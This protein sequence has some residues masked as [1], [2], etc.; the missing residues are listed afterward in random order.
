MS[1]QPDPPVTRPA[2]KAI[3]P[4]QSSQS[5]L[6]HT[7]AILADSAATASPAPATAC[8][9]NCCVQTAAAFDPLAGSQAVA[10]GMQTA[11]RIMQM[12]CPVEETLISKKL[13]DMPAVKQLEF[14]LMQRV[15][16]VVHNP[17]ALESIMQ[18]IRELG[19]QPELPDTHGQL[20]PVVAPPTTWWPMAV[21]AS[22]ALASEL[23]HWFALPTFWP[24]ALALLAI[25]SCGLV[26]SVG[27][28]VS[29]LLAPLAMPARYPSKEKADA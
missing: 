17:E 1:R 22:L 4:R 15:L 26:L 13:G 29:F 23:A 21:G 6:R 27:V 19:F 3:R 18:A 12:D 16:T 7:G 28:F 10:G 20:T 25:A 2:I 8:A 11:I 5:L 9:G 14:N 24:A